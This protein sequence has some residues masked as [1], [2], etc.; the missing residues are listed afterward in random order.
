MTFPSTRPTGGNADCRNQVCARA[1]AVVILALACRAKQAATKAR[2]RPE[3][4]AQQE[5]V[6]SSAGSSM[7]CL[8]SLM[9]PHNE[10]NRKGIRMVKR[11]C[12][13]RPMAHTSEGAPLKPVHVSG[14]MY[15][16]VPHFGKAC[17]SRAV[18]SVTTSGNTQADPTSNS[19]KAGSGS[20]SR[21]GDVKHMF[22]GLMSRCSAPAVRCKYCTAESICRARQEASPSFTA[23][24]AVQRKSYNS[25]PAK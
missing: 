13:T 4:K 23:P 19:C 21:T 10:C 18:A 7:A 12:T 11:M 2:A 3:R 14:A 24:F 17:K 22:S 15:S 9:L 20:P 6:K 1:S 25:G 5:S 8:M 16:F